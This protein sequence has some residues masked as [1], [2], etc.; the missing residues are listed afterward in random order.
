MCGAC[1]SFRYTY[2]S[3]NLLSHKN[4]GCSQHRDSWGCG[5][6]QRHKNALHETLSRFMKRYHVR[7]RVRRCTAISHA[8]ELRQ[9]D[10]DARA[11]VGG[12][13]GSRQ[14]D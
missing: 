11:V 1:R 5:V 6:I 10:A 3:I 13:R 9:A 8:V 14:P 12:C 2:F 4:D 7:S